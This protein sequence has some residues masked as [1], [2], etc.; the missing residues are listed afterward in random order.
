MKG[1]RLTPEVA[2]GGQLFEAPA[3]E[4]GVA[5]LGGV[6]GAV[7][8]AFPGWGADGDVSHQAAGVVFET[9]AHVDELAV[10]TGEVR[11][12]IRRIGSSFDGGEGMGL[13][14]AGVEAG[15]L[16]TPSVEVEAVGFEGIAEVVRYAHT[17]TGRPLSSY[18]RRGQ[19]V[20]SWSVW[21][22]RR[23]TT[24]RAWRLA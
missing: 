24:R 7:V 23:S 11:A 22:A 10:R 18:P 1:E 20:L 13:A 2:V 12:L 14:A 4:G 6:A 3:F 9:L 15:P 5:S 21:W 17:Q 19:R 8:D 16:V